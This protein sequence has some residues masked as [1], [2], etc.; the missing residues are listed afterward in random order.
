M[1]GNGN[2]ATQDTGAAAPELTAAL[3]A[4]QEDHR[5]YPSVLGRLQTSRLLLA[6]VPLPASQAGEMA[7]GFVQSA[8]G[9]LGLPVFSAVSSLEAFD[10]QARPL[11]VTLAEVAAMAVAERAEALLVDPAGPVPVVVEG[12]DLTR[13]ADGWEL[14]RVGDRPAWIRPD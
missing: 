11:P 5:H 14:G 10:A 8:S 6:L 1:T 9:R 2:P 12:E 4:Y 7:A 13:L 3:V